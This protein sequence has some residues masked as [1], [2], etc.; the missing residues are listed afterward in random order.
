[1]FPPQGGGCRG[2]HQQRGL[3]DATASG[4][5]EAHHHFCPYRLVRGCRGQQWRGGEGKNRFMRLDC[6]PSSDTT[7]NEESASCSHL[8]FFFPPQ[9]LKEYNRFDLMAPMRG[10]SPEEIRQLH[11]EGALRMKEGKDSRVRATHMAACKHATSFYLDA[12]HLVS[13]VCAAVASHVA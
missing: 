2:L 3:T 13:H 6:L 4:P 7:L 5:S 10:T 11:L 1:M 9:I 8:F 12:Q